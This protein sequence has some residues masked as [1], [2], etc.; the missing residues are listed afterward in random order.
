MAD[1][2]RLVERDDIQKIVSL[3]KGEKTYEELNWLLRDPYDSSKYSAYVAVNPDDKVVGM[4]GFFISRYTFGDKKIVGVMP[5]SWKIADGYKGISGVN[6]LNKVLSQ[7]QFSMTVQ[8]SDIA[9]KL[10]YAF[11]LRVIGAARV[12]IKVF[13]PRLYFISMKKERGMYSRLGNFVSA[14]PSYLIK[15]TRDQVRSL[16]IREIDKKQMDRNNPYLN[17]DYFE[18][19]VTFE[20]LRWLASCPILDTH[21]FEIKNEN[22]FFGYCLCFIK[23]LPN[24]TSRGRVVYKPNF[25]NDKNMLKELLTYLEDFF[26]KRGCCSVTILALDKASSDVLEEQ[27]FVNCKK[28][29]KPIYV[30]SKNGALTDLTID[31]WYMQ[32]TEGDK[33]Y[34]DI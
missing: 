4:I 28:K 5:M 2:I 32:Y 6:L 31:K 17:K 24:G 7:G 1:K 12:Y 10:Y 30:K 11:N 33:A 3:Y 15:H 18:K 22:R 26:I 34:R 25:G 27:H 20:Y 8:G 29:Q 13:Y 23:S 19:E 14:M 21:L 16:V 9:Q